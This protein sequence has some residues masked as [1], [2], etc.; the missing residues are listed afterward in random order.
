MA[1]QT[2]DLTVGTPWKQIVIFAI[3]LMISYLF[4]NLYNAVDSYIVGQLLGDE[5]LAAVSSSGSF[6]FLFTSFF[7]GLAIGCGSLVGKYFG[8]KNEERLSNAIHTTVAIGLVCSVFLTV[9]SEVFSPLILRLMGT[10]DDVIGESVSYFRGFFI[11]S[12]GLV[13]YAMLN[14]ILQGVGNSRRGLYYLIFSSLTNVVL[15]M[16][17]VKPLG[18]FGAGIA[19]AISQILSAI[20]AFLFLIKKG[21]IYQVQIKKIRFDKETTKRMLIL[22]VPSGIQN[23]VIGIA[24][25]CVQSFINSFGSSVM[26]GCG[27]YMKIEGFGFIPIN[28]FTGAITNYVSQNLG[29]KEYE[30]AKKGARFAI[31]TSILMAE[32][33]GVITYIFAPQLVGLFTSTPECIEAG[34]EHARTLSLFYCLL[35]YSHCVSSVCRGGGRP[36]VPMFVMLFDWCILRVIYINIAMRINH[37]ITLLFMAYPI[38]WAISSI[39]YI[40]YYYLSDWVH[41]F[42]RKVKPTEKL[43][44]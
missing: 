24:N 17:L 21:T 37:N 30:R 40:F 16:L 36:A 35:A 27:S 38:T 18:V 20:L 22:G 8:A 39:F 32:A 1:S 14:G 43:V 6:I 29:A 26:A 25:V 28:S 9:I 41:G 11:G 3:P 15:D 31:I 13:M 23:S 2:R 33:I 10:P 19:S 7:I 4:Q 42:E 34:V 44:K 12:I 5:S